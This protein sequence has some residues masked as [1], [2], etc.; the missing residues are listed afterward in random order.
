MVFDNNMFEVIGEPFSKND[1][2]LTTIGAVVLLKH[3]LVTFKIIFIAQNLSKSGTIYRDPKRGVHTLTKIFNSLKSSKYFQ[4]L[5]E[6][7]L[8]KSAMNKVSNTKLRLTVELRF[9][10]GLLAINIAPP[11][12]DRVW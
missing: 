1:G 6:T 4:K 9:L 8:I 7:R 2:F 5:A 3:V 10:A 12:T 11:P